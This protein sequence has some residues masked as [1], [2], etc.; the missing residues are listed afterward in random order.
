MGSSSILRDKLLKIISLIIGKDYKLDEELKREFINIEQ[1]NITGIDLDLLFKYHFSVGK[2]Y[3]NGKNWN[4]ADHHLLKILDNIPSETPNNTL[5]E[6]YM[7]RGVYYLIIQESILADDYFMRCYPLQNK[8]NIDLSELEILDIE[9]PWI[10]IEQSSPINISKRIKLYELLLPLLKNINISELFDALLFQLRC[11]EGV[12]LVRDREYKKSLDYFIALT[13]CF[14]RLDQK[15]LGNLRKEF[16]DKMGKDI[17]IQI[18]DSGTLHHYLGLI[19]HSLYNF[20]DALEN[21]RESQFYREQNGQYLDL[22]ETFINLGTVNLLEYSHLQALEYYERAIEIAEKHDLKPEMTQIYSNIAK[23]YQYDF[24]FDT[25]LSYA[26]KAYNIS[27]DLDQRMQQK[28]LST[29]GKSFQYLKHTEDAIT[30]FEQS[31]QILLNNKDRKDIN[32][33][34]Y[35]YYNLV[36]LYNR[37]SNLEQAKNI[38]F[39]F[40]NIGQYRNNP[41]IKAMLIISHID[42][43][44]YSGNL[45]VN[46]NRVLRLIKMVID[47]KLTNEVKEAALLQLFRL[48]LSLKDEYIFNTLIDSKKLLV[49]I[50]KVHK[51]T[52]VSYLIV[53]QMINPQNYLDLGDLI[54]ILISLREMTDLNDDIKIISK[55]LNALD[56]PS[57]HDLI[58]VTME[59]LNENLASHHFELEI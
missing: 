34:T 59:I 32:E 43:E 5:V 51:I 11:N 45:V 15:T 27:L 57:Y 16:R 22:L 50:K 42:T 12:F 17:E 18:F 40:S 36:I 10:K 14:S 58:E 39:D 35:N 8:D 6:I 1:V 19:Y 55:F 24:D 9:L 52:F 41:N 26:Q 33:I 29:L 3:F 25:A 38:L 21:Y 56:Q 37:T 4:M 20:E 7:M 31:L 28:A 49:Y 44:Y 54:E 23:I 30:S 48:D 47:E 2:T 46:P 53:K 13:Y